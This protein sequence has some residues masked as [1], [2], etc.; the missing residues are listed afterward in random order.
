MS[1]TFLVILFKLFSIAGIASKN[2]CPMAGQ[3]AYSTCTTTQAQD[4]AGSVWDVGVP[5]QAFTD[6]NCGYTLTVGQP[7]YGECGFPPNGW[8]VSYNPSY[9]YVDP[10]YW[11]HPNNPQA[12]Q[13]AFA[14][15]SFVVSYSNT[16]VT[17]WPD[18]YT[19][20]YQ[21]MDGETITEITGIDGWRLVI[22]YSAFN[23]YYTAVEDDL[24]P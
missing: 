17:S 4:A 22:A 13:L 11:S 20:G 18:T 2:N 8:S 12:G 14:G 10:I 15:G 3:F 24:T 19:A 21:K 23:N 6:G 9:V 7:T 1:T 16:Y 5:A